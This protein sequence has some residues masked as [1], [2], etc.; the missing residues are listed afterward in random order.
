MAAYCYGL[1]GF[2]I[3]IEPSGTT[4]R[5]DLMYLYDNSQLLQVVRIMVILEIWITNT[6]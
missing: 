1:L 4:C 5:T 3:E 2:R 6:Y